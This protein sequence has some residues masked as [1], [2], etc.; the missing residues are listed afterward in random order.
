MLSRLLRAALEPLALRSSEAR[1]SWQTLLAAAAGVMTVTLGCIVPFPAMA[2]LAARTLSRRAAIVA[3]LAAVAVNQCIGFLLLGYP[4]T[5]ETVIWAPVFAL[6][7]VAAFAVS[8][9]IAS[10]PLAFVASFATYEGMLAAYTFVTSHSL[11]A[12]APSIVGQVAL[13]NVIGLAV[14]C[15]A[16]CAVAAIERSAKF[17]AGATQ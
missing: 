17:G 4:R 12:F 2:T 13:G 10:A 3:L 14:L 5:L 15:P 16:Y 11:A 7:T 8:E 9:R 6:A 1:F